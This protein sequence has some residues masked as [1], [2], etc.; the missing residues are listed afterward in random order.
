MAF[1]DCKVSPENPLER[2]GSLPGHA[3]LHGELPK[4]RDPN[5]KLISVKQI[6]TE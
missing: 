1:I 4:I 2:S 6:D 5:L 3:A